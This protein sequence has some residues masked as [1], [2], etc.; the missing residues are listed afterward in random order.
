MQASP[1]LRGDFETCVVAALDLLMD[2]VMNDS[3]ALETC[4]RGLIPTKYGSRTAVAYSQ[5]AID[6][7]LFWRMVY[8]EDPGAERM[9]I[10]EFEGRLCVFKDM[11][12]K[13]VLAI[14]RALR[15]R[16]PV[17]GPHITNRSLFRLLDR[18]ILRL[19]PDPNGWGNITTL[20]DYRVCMAAYCAGALF[21]SPFQDAP[22]RPDSRL[23]AD[24]LAWLNMLG[25]ITVYGQGHADG[26]VEDGLQYR[27]RS[28]LLCFMQLKDFERA[29]KYV[30]PRGFHAC[31]WSASG[32]VRGANKEL[33]LARTVRGDGTDEEVSKETL[34]D[35]KENGKPLLCDYETI[36]FWTGASEPIVRDFLRRDYCICEFA[37]L[38]W[39]FDGRVEKYVVRALQ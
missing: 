23:G 37:A 28:H 6:E 39:S 33:I 26:M 35:L 5:R 27:Q 22:L 34:T 19:K 4:S 13:E 8:E 17:G 32:P 1:L 18:E 10:P 11:E 38:D 7:N 25:V 12:A 31:A 21:S 15:A 2:D 16:D 24:Y 30:T 14:A 29:Y 9:D 20:D 3:V 36:A